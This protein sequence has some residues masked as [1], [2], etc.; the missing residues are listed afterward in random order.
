MADTSAPAP[1]P[2]QD[3]MATASAT[4]VRSPLP[5]GILVLNDTIEIDLGRRIPWYSNQYASAYTAKSR[6]GD[7]EYVAYVCEPAY[8]PRNRMMPTYVSL[9]NPH[10]P[11]LI[12]S[13]P[14]TLAGQN[15][16]RYVV[17]YENS[18]GKPVADHDVG[19]TMG[20]RSEKVMEKFVVP[21]TNI[22]KDFRDND[23]VRLDPIGI[24]LWD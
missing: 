11:K 3:R 6:Q 24:F 23:L 12:G 2:S 16:Q 13:G 20:I 19:L 5:A 22:L 4:V 1:V 17:V 14:A 10:L 7:G 8:T 18:M 21:L 9:G 15:I